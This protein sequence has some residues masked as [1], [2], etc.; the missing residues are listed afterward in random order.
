[1]TSTNSSTLPAYFSMK[2]SKPQPICVEVLQQIATITDLE[3]PDVSGASPIFSLIS[4]HVSNDK[5]D[6]ASNKGIFVV[7]FFSISII[8]DY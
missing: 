3:C 7:S 5:V 4:R 8:E 1:M 6:S 2:L